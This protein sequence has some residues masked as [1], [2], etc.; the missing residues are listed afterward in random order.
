[1]VTRESRHAYF[2]ILQTHQI[3]KDLRVCWPQKTSSYPYSRYEITGYSNKFVLNI[4]L[5]KTFFVPLDPHIKR[6]TCVFLS[7]VFFIMFTL[8]HGHS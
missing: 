4:W 7:I 3:S 6:G 2:C 1:M 8:R 5:C